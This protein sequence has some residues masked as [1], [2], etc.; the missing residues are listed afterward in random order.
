MFLS[1]RQCDLLNFLLVALF[2]KMEIVI[3]KALNVPC[4]SFICY[5]INIPV[6]YLTSFNIFSYIFARVCLAQL[7]EKGHS[8]KI[9]FIAC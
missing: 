3:Q 1:A 4:N 2:R 5:C 8:L 6:I 9:I 7:K